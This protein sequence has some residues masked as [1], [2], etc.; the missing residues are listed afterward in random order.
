MSNAGD[1]LKFCEAQQAQ[2]VRT[3][4]RLVQLES[5]TTDKAAV[6]RCGAEVART[7]TAIG[8]H[9]DRLARR[10]SGDHLRAEIGGA[11]RQL[12][13]LCHFDTVWPVGQIQTMPLREEDGRL[14]GP[15]VFDMK[16]GL[17]LGMLA[18]RALSE[19][20]SGLRRRIVMLCTADEETGS[21]S[22]RQAIEEEAKRSEAVLVLEP[23]AQHGALKTHRKG[24]GEYRLE[25]TGV[26][27]HA[28]IDPAAGASAITELARQILDLENLQDLSPGVTLN[29]GIVSG[30]TRSN[31]V[32]ERA[33]AV[34]DV[35]VP[36]ASDAQ[37]LDARMRAVRAHN[38]RVRIELTG[39]IGR[40][41]MERSPK[42]LALY[43]LAREVGSKLGL[44]LAEVGTGGGSD[45]NFTAAQGVPT[46][47]GLGAIG[48]GAHAKHEHI[49]LGSLASRAALLA[50]LLDRLSGG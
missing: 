30:G 31:V 47:D 26:P 35:R 8:F 16:S 29:V 10:E 45:G 20:G 3:I 11:P 32:P 34:V 9:V 46:L 1:L 23:A 14:Y 48:D 42:T 2:L 18:V 28:G 4:G 5:P 6:D 12:L 27:A 17:C 13:L 41:P 39:G 44:E 19:A 22:S 38:P 25:I 24:C 40:P 43:E 37:Q 50:G 36:T 33:T 7:L 49:E 21:A 15:G